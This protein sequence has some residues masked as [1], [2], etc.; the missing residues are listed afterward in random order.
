MN[1]EIAHYPFS[2]WYSEFSIKN[3]EKIENDRLKYINDKWMQDEY[4]KILDPDI[5]SVWVQ[6]DSI[7]RNVNTKANKEEA[8]VCCKII[9]KFVKYGQNI[10]ENIGVIAPFRRQVNEIKN[11]VAANI[12]D[13]NSD[14]VDTVDRF[15]GSQKEIIIIS[16]CSGENDNFLESD[17]RRLNVALTRSKFKRIIIGDISKAG[18]DLGGILNDGYTQMVKL[19]NG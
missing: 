17:Y 14:L 19:K 16:T 10:N 6:V 9:E 3:F 5:P 13:S 2:K 7:K 1:K 4:R 15:Q 18:K 8:N 11:L 12:N